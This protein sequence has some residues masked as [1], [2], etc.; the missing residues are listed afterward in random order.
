MF[1]RVVKVSMDDVLVQVWVANLVYG[2]G[3][4]RFLVTIQ[5]DV[6]NS[7]IRGIVEADFVKG[8]DEIFKIYL[9]KIIILNQ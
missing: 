4:Y 9:K 5:A 6:K 8:G 2:F 3:Y 7:E 1:Q